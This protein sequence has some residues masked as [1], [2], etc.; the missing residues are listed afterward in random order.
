MIF[1]GISTDVE[2]S[3]HFPIFSGSSQAQ[4]GLSS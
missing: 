1:E 3:T 4:G 2:E